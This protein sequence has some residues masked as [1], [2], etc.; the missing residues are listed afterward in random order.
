MV[1]S[2]H[3]MSSKVE[4]GGSAAANS[5]A[6]TWTRRRKTSALCAFETSRAVTL[7]CIAVL[8]LLAVEQL[9]HPCR[10]TPPWRS[11]PHVKAETNFSDDYVADRSTARSFLGAGRCILILQHGSGERAPSAWKSAV[12]ERASVVVSHLRT[13]LKMN[14]LQALARTPGHRETPERAAEDY[15]IIQLVFYCIQRSYGRVPALGMRFEGASI[16]PK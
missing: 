10:R 3:P 9:S 1:P 13:V 2:P 7:S 16:P 11:C 15:A 5:A 6:S 12:I 8:C 14:R 4:T